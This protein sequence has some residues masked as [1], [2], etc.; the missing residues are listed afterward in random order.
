MGASV[1]ISESWYK[2]VALEVPDWGDWSNGSHSVYQTR[3]VYQRDFIPPKEL[4]ITADVIKQADGGGFAIVRFGVDQVLSRDDPDFEEDLL[5]ALNLLQE[6]VGR[7][8]VFPSTTTAEDYAKTIVVD[9]EILP[10]GAVGAVLAKMLHGKEPITVDQERVM[11]S[12][13]AAIAKLEPKGY[14]VGTNGFLRV[15]LETS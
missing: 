7:V 2:T 6:N 9:W 13:L 12:R 4:E 5:Y 14:I 11:R 10:P 1:L 8:D 3:E 15:C